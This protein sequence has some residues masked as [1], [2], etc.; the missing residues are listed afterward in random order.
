VG[1]KQWLAIAEIALA[2]LAWISD[3]DI[4]GWL[5]ATLAACAVGAVIWIFAG[6]VWLVVA[7]SL[8]LVLLVGVKL[9]VDRADRRAAA[10]RR[11][12]PG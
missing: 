3:L 1:F 8:Y 5:V 7:A 2:N 9:A 12:A 10:A 11:R 4:E 6:P